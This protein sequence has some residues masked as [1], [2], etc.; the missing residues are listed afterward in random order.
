M[1]GNHVATLV[2][3]SFLSLAQ[4]LEGQ[5][6]GAWDA[7]SLCD[8]WRVRNVVA[9]MSTAAR[10]SPEEY[11]EGGDFMAASDRLAI[12][13]G[14]LDPQILLADLRAEQLHRW[15]PP[16][17]GASGALNHVVIH[18]LD[19]TTPLDAGPW[20]DDDA[21]REVLDALTKGAVHTYFGTSIHGVRLRATDLE[22]S[23]GK[24][25]AM[26]G[27]ADDLILVLAGRKL[28]PGRIQGSLP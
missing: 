7:Q 14:D 28:A 24:G 21:R 12:R 25:S 1:A 5:S 3:Q 27:A 8:H 4:L 18:G 23:H 6:P 2:R 13:D 11:M 20:L 19:V 26:S 17:G 9:H 16:G 10:Y 15:V 22:W